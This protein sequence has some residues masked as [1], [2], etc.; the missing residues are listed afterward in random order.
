MPQ[1]LFLPM[2]VTVSVD[3]GTKILVAARRNK[4]PI[5][6]SCGVCHCGTCVVK[7]VDASQGVLTEKKDNESELLQKLGF[8]DNESMRLACQTKVMAGFVTIELNS[9]VA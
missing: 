9:F 7:V 5:T 1:I 8:G 3:E 4:I 2:Q 6:F